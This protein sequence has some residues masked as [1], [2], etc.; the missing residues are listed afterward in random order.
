MLDSLKHLREQDL[1]ICIFK[2][3]SVSLATVAVKD[4]CHDA[5]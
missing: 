3:S 2:M 1:G 5:L 4:Q